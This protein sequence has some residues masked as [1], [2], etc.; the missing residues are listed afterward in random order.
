MRLIDLDDK[1]LIACASLLDEPHHLP[2]V[3]LIVGN[4]FL[5]ETMRIVAPKYP[6]MLILDGMGVDI[7]PL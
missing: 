3:T 5:I 2:I 6:V 1:Q 7:V 4:M